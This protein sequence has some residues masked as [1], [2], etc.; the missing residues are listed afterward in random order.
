MKYLQPIAMPFPQEQREQQGKFSVF[1][2]LRCL[3]DPG[4]QADNVYKPSLPRD[5]H[6][7]SPRLEELHH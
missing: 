6:C 3:A 4:E 7:S 5:S 1:S 2:A